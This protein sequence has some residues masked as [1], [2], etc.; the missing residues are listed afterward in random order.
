MVA[1]LFVNSE[2]SKEGYW[3]RLIFPARRDAP[4]GF[5]SASALEK[6]R[7]QYRPVWGLCHK[8]TR[9]ACLIVFISDTFLKSELP[10]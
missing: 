6:L 7:M 8:E 2:L 10:E 5:I 1:H 9:Q 3:F 4:H